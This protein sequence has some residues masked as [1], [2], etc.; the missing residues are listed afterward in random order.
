MSSRYLR[1]FRFGAVRPA[2]LVAAGLALLPAAPA[3]AGVYD[4]TIGEATINV[5][6]KNKPALAINGQVPGPTLR[7]TEG[8][9]VDDLS[10]VAG[11]RFFF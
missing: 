2:A 7:F 1:L 11:A 6:G 10:F 3:Q 8:E 4:L 5:S 9:E